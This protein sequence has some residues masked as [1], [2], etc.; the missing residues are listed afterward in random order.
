M[1]DRTMAAPVLVTGGTGTLGRRIVPR[2]RTA[3]CAV[4]VLSRRVHEPAEGVEFVTGDL[5]T[6]DGVDAAVAGVGT[7]V[8]CGGSAKGDDLK[9]RHLVRAAVRAG[10]Q[11]LV[12]VSVVGA[13]RIPVRSAVDRAAFG[14]FA[15]K[16]AAEELIADCGV[17][18]TTLRATQFHES[19]QAVLESAARM[20]VVPVFAGSASSRS[21]PARSPT[22]SSSWPSARRPASC[23][24]W[25]DPALTRWTSWPAATC[26]RPAGAGRCCRYECPAAPHAR[27]VPGR[28]WRRSAPSACA[29]GRTRWPTG[30]RHRP[31]VAR[32][33][34]GSRRIRTTTPPAAVPNP[35]CAARLAGSSTGPTRHSLIR[36]IERPVPFV[37][38]QRDIAD[39]ATRGTASTP[40]GVRLAGVV[41]Q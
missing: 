29:P 15:A 21:T 34:P 4:R 25:P 6:G 18:W 31:H 35:V 14:Y 24:T 23:P 13:D 33:P 3:Q 22:G 17:P 19:L 8:H 36:R 32:T 12:Y 16:R 27:C 41:D 37:D 11:H 1:S 9:A 20:P 38:P 39:L 28:T 30:A 10:V 5:E 7:V 40:H 26:A 2:L